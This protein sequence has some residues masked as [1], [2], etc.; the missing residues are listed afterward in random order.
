MRKPLLSGLRATAFLPIT[1]KI[2]RIKI[3]EFAAV[4]EP[5]RYLLGDK[6]TDGSFENFPSLVQSE[7]DTCFIF[8]LMKAG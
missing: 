5:G 7:G 6:H 3:A 1:P 8:S 4:F 2:L